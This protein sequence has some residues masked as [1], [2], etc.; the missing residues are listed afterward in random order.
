MANVIEIKVLV[1]RY[2]DKNAVDGLSFTVKSGEIFGFLGPNGSG[3]STT[4]KAI[5]GLVFPNSGS[6]RVNGLPPSDP[7]SRT[8]VGFMPEEATYYRFLN[9]REILSFYGKVFGLGRQERDR[10]VN[11]VLDLVGLSQAAHR[12]LSTFS[13]GMVQKVS[14]AQ[15][16]IQD[17]ETLILDEPTTGLDPLAKMQLR[18]ILSDL[19]SRGKTIFFSSHELS[20]VELLCDSIVIIQAGKALRSGALKEVLGGQGA[21]SLEQFFLKTIQGAK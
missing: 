17:P 12:P 13:K 1:V 20:E 19:K 4:I 5:L 18:G 8:K 2:A 21:H 7:R 3:K 15:A 9:P 16:L 11:F 14:L 10:R 6:A